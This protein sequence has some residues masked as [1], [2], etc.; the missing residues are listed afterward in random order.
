MAAM[1]AN[2]AS[3]R[4]GLLRRGASS[5]RRPRALS[6]PRRASGAIEL[7]TSGVGGVLAL[8]TVETSVG[9]GVIS[10]GGASSR[11]VSGS[12]ATDIRQPASVVA[13]ARGANRQAGAE[14][15]NRADGEALR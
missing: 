7:V 9:G 2:H 10:V 5:A 6:T 1:S 11:T 3:A 13:S 12:L 15:G 8:E 14:R 4:T